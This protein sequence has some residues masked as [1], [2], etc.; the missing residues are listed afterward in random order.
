MKRVIANDKDSALKL[1]ND[2]DVLIAPHQESNGRF[3]VQ[4]KINPRMM[5]SGRMHF[6]MATKPFYN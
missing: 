2:F 6:R 5:D 3:T 4:H 1:I